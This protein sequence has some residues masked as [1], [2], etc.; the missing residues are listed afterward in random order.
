[1]SRKFDALNVLDEDDFA[2]IQA[3]VDAVLEAKPELAQIED[4][5]ERMEAVARTDEMLHVETN[6]VHLRY[7]IFKALT[8]QSRPFNEFYEAGR[9]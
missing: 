4:D 6:G 5:H 9:N 8:G 1:M 3:K 2:V 7:A